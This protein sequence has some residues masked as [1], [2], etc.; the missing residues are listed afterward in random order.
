MIP[1]FVF[2]NFQKNWITLVSQD[3]DEISLSETVSSPRGGNSASSTMRTEEAKSVDGSRRL[4]F[5]TTT[6]STS[7]PEE[8]VDAKEFNP[9]TPYESSSFA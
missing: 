2:K 7:P 6:S 4:T 8:A 5:V 9:P 3:G 1:Y